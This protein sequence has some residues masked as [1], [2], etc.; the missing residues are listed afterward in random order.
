MNRE[1]ERERERESELGPIGLSHSSRW[2]ICNE[3][4]HLF[5]AKLLIV[6]LGIET[7]DHEYFPRRRRH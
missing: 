1:R 2:N 7:R 4:T 5:Y 3:H 6:M